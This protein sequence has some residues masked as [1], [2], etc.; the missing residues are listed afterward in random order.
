[1]KS[2]QEML[3]ILSSMDEDH[4]M[5]ALEA[6]GIDCGGSHY[7]DEMGAEGASEGLESW[8]DTR[9]EMPQSKRPPLVDMS[10]VVAAQ[11]QV[12]RRPTV[13][14]GREVT[15]LENMAPPPGEVTGAY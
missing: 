6:N 5:R 11:K 7:M 14:L 4:L 2:R 15:G 13:D 12:R 9:I 8:N 3:A 1:M 10:K